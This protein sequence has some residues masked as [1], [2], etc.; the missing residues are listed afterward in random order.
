[1]RFVRYDFS[2]S[3][4]ESESGIRIPLS[5]RILLVIKTILFSLHG[6]EQQRDERRA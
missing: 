2:I 4:V 3:C 1:M 6:R 5:A